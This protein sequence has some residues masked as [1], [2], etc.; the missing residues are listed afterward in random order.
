MQ[1]FCLLLL[2]LGVTGSLVAGQ[3]P[4]PDDELYALD[5]AER[6]NSAER[7]PTYPDGVNTIPGDAEVNYPVL[8]SIM[9]TSFNC[10]GRPAGF[11]ADLEARCQVWH[12]CDVDERQQSF[13]CTNGTIF[14]QAT[15][16]CEWWYNTNC[17]ANEVEKEYEH[18]L[19]LY[20]PG[21][22][23]H[24]REAKENRDRP[25]SQ[26][27][28]P[29]QERYRLV[30]NEQ[31]QR[32]QQRPQLQQ[33]PAPRQQQQQPA[34]RPAPRPQD[35][36]PEKPLTLN[37]QQ[38]FQVSDSRGQSNENQQASTRQ[39]QPT[40]QQQR[41][42]Q[43]QSQPQPRPTPNYREESNQRHTQPPQQLSREELEARRLAARD[44]FYST[45]ARTQQENRINQVPTSSAVQRQYV[46]ESR[47][48]NRP[49]QSQQPQKPNYQEPT[50][51]PRN[52]EQAPPK[53]KP[54]SYD[55]VPGEPPQ[56]NKQKFRHS[57]PRKHNVQFAA[58]SSRNFQ[59]QNDDE[60]Q[61]PE[62]SQQKGFPFYNP[63]QF[64]EYTAA[65]RQ[66]VDNVEAPTARKVPAPVEQTPERVNAYLPTARTILREAPTRQ[67]YV[68]QTAAPEQKRRP[69]RRRK[70]PKRIAAIRAERERLALLA[71]SE[72]RSFVRSTTTTTAQPP[73]VRFPQRQRVTQ[74]VTERPRF[75]QKV[76]ERPQVT[77]RI[78]ERPQV[79]QKVTEPDFP[80]VSRGESINRNP[81][82]NTFPVIPRNLETSARAKSSEDNNAYST[83]TFNVNQLP[84]DS[85]QRLILRP[86]NSSA[87]RVVVKRKLRNKKLN[88]NHQRTFVQNN[89]VVIVG[90]FGTTESVQKRVQ[91]DFTQ[92]HAPVKRCAVAEGEGNSFKILC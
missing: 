88:A 28:Q 53:K 19:D 64:Q 43:Q 37:L 68:E 35:T 85:D 89:D 76:T 31:E 46:A 11:Y 86:K 22:L 45:A 72:E 60:R 57:T 5:L 79:T 69:G 14:S 44:E 2:L 36:Y 75:Q 7:E 27:R 21:E 9:K 38:K 66:Y 87:A 41:A 42:Q 20:K 90:G 8:H 52:E 13:L 63:R 71:A 56:A 51:R 10:I 50:N 25:K 17:D 82:Y 70:D 49:A 67:S 91:N 29:E 77:K 4:N 59:N 3:E 1:S 54:V 33:Q 15:R 32:P 12:I 26:Q 78:T 6:V 40:P 24:L 48:D 47:N 62:E 83:K 81:N 80:Q 16:V 23:D 65:T 39:Q 92:V 73:A 58:S 34:Q 18:N 30:N 84:D 61:I 55:F 74:D